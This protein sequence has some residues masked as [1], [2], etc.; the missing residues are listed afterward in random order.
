MSINPS[1]EPLAIP[2]LD[3]HERHETLDSTND[4]ARR[5][6]ASLAPGETVLITAE[7]QTA[8]RGRGANRWWTGS[9][10]LAFSLLFDPARRGVE[11]S[12]FPLISLA[13]ALAIVETAQKFMPQPSI[14]LRWPNDVY[15]GQRK[16]A[17]ILVEALADG[18][19]ILGVGVNVNNSLAEAPQEL[20]GIVTTLRDMSGAEVDRERFLRKLLGNLDEELK[21]LATSPTVLGRRAHE[22][23]LQRGNQL[24]LEIGGRRESG[25]CQGIAEDGAL[26]LRTPEGPKRYYSGVV[27]ADSGLVPISRSTVFYPP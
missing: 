11:K 2:W 26:E 1:R 19:H 16:L 5:I 22:N 23:C 7:A 20:Q 3:R 4:H 10:A 21:L 14:G 24:T 25:V 18:R 6:S 17:G 9:G 8:G 13:A 27:V 15:V 12:L